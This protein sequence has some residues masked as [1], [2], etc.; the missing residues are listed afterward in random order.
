MRTLS[1][2][3]CTC[4][5]L[6]G[7]GDDDLEGIVNEL[8]PADLILLRFV[9]PNEA[10]PGQVI[11]VELTVRNVGDE[12]T[13]TEVP[14][15]IYLSA[16]DSITVEDRAVEVTSV[17]RLDKNDEVA[18][19]IDVL[20][21]AD[22]QP[23]VLQ[24]LGAIIDPGNFVTESAD[25]NNS[26]A[27]TDG[28]LFT[29]GIDLVGLT[30]TGPL[31]SCPGQ[32]VSVNAVVLNAGTVEARDFT[33]GVFLSDDPLI[34]RGDELL[35][36][37]SVTIIP[38]GSTDSRNVMVTIPAGATVQPGFLGLIADHRE[39]VTEDD[40]TNNVAFDSNGVQVNGEASEPND[41]L[42]TSGIITAPPATTTAEPGFLCPANDVDFWRVDLTDGEMV[43]LSLG[44]LTMDLQLTLL[45]LNGSVLATSNAPGTMSESIVHVATYTG[46]HHL[47]VE[48]ASGLEE[49]AGAP[50]SVEVTRP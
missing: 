46:A 40:E 29:G 45:D 47:R 35:A 1:L 33:V 8:E 4:L 39:D 21:P 27:D 6:A 48:G 24:F 50:Y 23:G 26:L 12:G 15:T 25:S 14:L 13:P 22:V 20:I 18:A 44:A 31:A 5:L 38:A 7:C 42:A 28:I 34:T 36:E 17:R 9:A 3:L 11:Q 37:Y 41:T 2:T 10:A 30:L 43:Q 49:E 16:D 19:V 32:D